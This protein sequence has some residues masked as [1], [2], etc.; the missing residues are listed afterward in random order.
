MIDQREIAESG[1]QHAAQALPDVEEPDEQDGKKG[2][3]GGDD[4]VLRER[5]NE[6]AQGE[7]RSAQQKYSGISAQEHAPGRR[8]VAVMKQEE[9]VSE[10]GSQHDGKKGKRGGE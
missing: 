4:L 8:G 1:P 3:H 10:S 7:Q 2:K 5:G 9:H 6:R